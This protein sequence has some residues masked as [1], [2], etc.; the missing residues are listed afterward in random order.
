LD[1]VDEGLL[2]F[3]LAARVGGAEEVE[4]VWGP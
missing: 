3:G 4:E 2:D 1:L